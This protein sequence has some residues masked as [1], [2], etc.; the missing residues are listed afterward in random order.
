M[1]QRKLQ[2]R[3]A[4]RHA[5][6]LA[7]RLDL[8]RLVDECRGGGDIVVRGACLHVA[9]QDAGIVGTAQNHRDMALGALG[10]EFLKRAL[11]QQRVAPS[12]QHAVEVA[13][14]DEASA[15]VC[16]VDAHADGADDAGAAQLVERAIA[17]VHHRLEALLEHGAVL[18]G[19]EIDVMDQGDVDLLQPEPQVRVLQRAHDTI[20][21]IVE[22]RCEARQAV[23]TKVGRRLLAGLHGV[24]DAADL[25]R[26]HVAVARLFPQRRTHAQLAAAVA[27]VRR[28]VEVADAGVVAVVGEFYRLGVGD[29]RAETTHRRAA[30]PQLRHFQFGLANLAAL[31]RRHVRFLRRRE[32]VR[33]GFGQG[34]RRPHER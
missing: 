33:I 21:G 20:V 6:A 28:G 2:G 34:H 27:V 7:Y 29:G 10:Q 30:Q 9:R 14:L 8:L 17:P 11:L 12:Q 3:G 23:L 18:G 26:Q 19:P 25:G 15:R 13:R 32:R 1:E 5:V 24:H 31:E 16:L 22:D 4:E